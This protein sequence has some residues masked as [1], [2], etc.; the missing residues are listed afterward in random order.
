MKPAGGQIDNI[1]R[2]L[3]VAV[4]SALVYGPDAGLADERAAIIAA[5][6]T[7]PA[8]DPFSV[9]EISAEK[10]KEDAAIIA[11]ELS[12]LS[13]FGGRKLV[14]IRNAGDSLTSSITAALKFLNSR[15]DDNSFLLVTAG[16]L[17]AR[18]SLRLLFEKEKHA[19]AIPCYQED[20][21]S[22]A[23]V[24]RGRLK[25]AGFL[26]EDGVIETISA[27]LVGD[28][29]ILNSELEKLFLFKA[30]DKNITMSDV[31]ELLVDS[32]ETSLDELCISLA[33]RDAAKLYR[34]FAKALMQ[35]IEPVRIIRHLLGYFGRINIVY[36]KIR[37]RISEQE[38]IAGLRPPIFWKNLPNF[39]RHIGSWA[40]SSS[41]DD[42]KLDKVFAILLQAEL[43]CKRMGNP[44]LICADSL[45]R[46]CRIR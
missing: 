28:R 26:W 39:K 3:P 40:K 2:N 10:I 1:I 44:E 21:Q 7:G 36:G 29:M 9:T 46:I 41:G 4:K 34:L 12:S 32:G 22:L 25:A 19:Y 24:V 45:L 11:E 31:A 8:P 37:S 30:E 33:D 20:A 42:N 43:D 35:G 16:E 13:F 14:K 18:S 17:G 6:I 38:A 5:G 27:N 15:P 23:A